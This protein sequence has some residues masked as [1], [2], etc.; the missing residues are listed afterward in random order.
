MSAGKFIPKLLTVGIWNIEGLYEK[1]NSTKLCKME[2]KSFQNTLKNFDILCLQETHIGNNEVLKELKDFHTIPHCRKKS[3]NNRYFGEFL[4]L[5]RKLIRKGVK[6]METDDKDIFELKLLKKYFALDTDI[7]LIFTYASPINSC[8]TKARTENVI[9]TVEK[10]IM[11]TENNCLIMG[12]LNGRTKLGDDFVRDEND[13]HSPINNLPYTRDE[14]LSRAN[15]DLTAIDQQGKKILEFCR[16]SSYRILN[17][18]VNG[19]KTGK[20]TRYPSNLRDEPSVIDYA[21]SSTSLINIIHSSSAL[22]FTGLSDHCCIS[23]CIKIN[24]SSQLSEQQSI[25]TDITECKIHGTDVTYTYDISRRDIFIQNILS[26]NSLSKLT[27][28]LYN[29]AVEIKQDQID[30][31]IA[32]LDN[33][34]LSAA[35]KSF[36]TKLRNKNSPKSKQKN[37]QKWYNKECMKHRKALRNASKLMS[38]YPFDKTLRKK[39]LE[40]RAAYKK[41]CRKAEKSFRQCLTKQLV[42]LGQAD[43]KTFWNIIDKMNRWGREKMTLLIK[44][45]L[46]SGKNILKIY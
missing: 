31:S 33:I 4:V 14:K 40:S 45:P 35:K 10:K 36:R 41:I 17:G 44:L 15:M 28:M 25:P 7:N 2:T 12:D 20:F 5:I 19:D 32:L 38:K 21:L 29:D 30:N 3:E 43:P 24:D 39:F 34:L 1:I 26:D 37:G 42:E 16:S 22:P 6:I 11:N 46:R 18:R 23:A 9:D 27:N 13:E 8:Y